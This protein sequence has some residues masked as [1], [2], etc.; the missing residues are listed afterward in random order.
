MEVKALG[1]KLCELRKAHGMRQD[2]VA[3]ALR[4]SRQKYSRIENGEN[5]PSLVEL[6]R[7]AL[8]FHTTVSELVSDDDDV[9]VISFYRNADDSP[10]INYINDVIDMFF[11]NKLVHDRQ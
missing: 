5:D 8:L 10:E 11:K 1:K 3:E 6:N 9:S 2:A 4:V 7:L